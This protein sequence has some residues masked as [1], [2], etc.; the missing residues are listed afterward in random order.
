MEVQLLS[1]EENEHEQGDP[2]MQESSGAY[3]VAKEGFVLLQ[4]APAVGPRQYDWTRKQL[5]KT[6]VYARLNSMVWFRQKEKKTYITLKNEFRAKIY[7]VDVRE[8][9]FRNLLIGTI[10]PLPGVTKNFSKR[11]DVFSL[12]VWEMGTLLTLGLTDSCEF[13]HDPFK[14]RSDEGKVRKVLKVEPTPDGNGRFFNLSVQNRLLNVD[15]NIYIPITKG[16]YAVIVSTFNYII[17]HIM[18][19]STFTN[20][21]KPEESQPYNRP[22]SSPELEWRRNGLHETYCSN[23]CLEVLQY[24]VWIMDTCIR[25]PKL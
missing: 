6:S 5:P 10:Q 17:P 16:E 11:K 1:S 2:P 23:F 9:K 15:E 12:S 13:F 21:I 18:G 7:I 8:M 20:S 25:Y 14:G 24:P 4:F 19:W 22:Q 3:K